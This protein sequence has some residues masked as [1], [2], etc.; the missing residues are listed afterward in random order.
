MNKII[1]KMKSKLNLNFDEELS[2][3][4]AFCESFE[5][6][7]E[8]RKLYL[9]AIVKYDKICLNTYGQNTVCPTINTMEGRSDV[10]YTGGR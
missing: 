3:F 1:I 9:K 2:N 8:V 7:W 4:V 6:A 5:N 10:S